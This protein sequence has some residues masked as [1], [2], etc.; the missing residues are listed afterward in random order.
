MWMQPGQYKTL[1]GGC[2]HDLDNHR[3]GGCYGRNKNPNIKD[4]TDEGE[5][6][7]CPPGGFHPCVPDCT[8]GHSWEDHHHGCIMNPEFPGECHPFGICR[9]VTGDECEATQFEGRY[10]GLKGGKMCVCQG[11]A[12][13]ETLLMPW[14]AKG[15]SDDR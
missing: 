8:C 9:G 14:Q 15:I 3:M 4:C 13:C 12:N 1:C 2:W 5:R 6:C 7:K 11:Y 10:T